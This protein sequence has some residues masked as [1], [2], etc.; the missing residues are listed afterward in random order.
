[1]HDIPPL[2]SNPPGAERLSPPSEAVAA[3]IRQ[4]AR[5]LAL[6]E[7]QVLC[8]APIQV[9]GLVYRIVHYG[10]MDPKGVTVMLTIGEVGEQELNSQLLS[11][12]LM[13]NFSRPAGLA[14]YFA[15]APEVNAIVFC[16]RVELDRFDDGAHAI[17]QVITG[18]TAN[19]RTGFD[20]LIDRLSKQE[21]AAAMK[22]QTETEVNDEAR[23]PAKR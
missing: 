11:H 4:F 2:S 6:D 14:G 15:M 16:L 20:V 9:Q 8:G 10:E 21:E 1:M 13:M 3:A 18:L 19:L 22:V 23:T 12:L 17:A 7:D 5:G